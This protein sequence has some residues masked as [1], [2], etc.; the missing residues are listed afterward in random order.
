MITRFISFVLLLSL[1]GIA[2]F[3]ILGNQSYADNLGI[4]TF[5][6]YAL[7]VVGTV[8]SWLFKKKK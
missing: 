1:L 5:C 6:L 2:G 4:I 3:L 8:L 7:L